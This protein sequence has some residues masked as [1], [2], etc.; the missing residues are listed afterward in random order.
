MVRLLLLP[1]LLTI[2]CDVGS[3][4]SDTVDGCDPGLDADNDGLNECEEWEHGTDPDKSD[5]DGDGF[6]DADELACLSNPLDGDEGCYAC[7]WGHNDP[8]DLESTG[9]D[10]GDVIENLVFVD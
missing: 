1:A 4:T 6:D 7:G 8:G 3:D 5:S 9:D 10:E 2:G